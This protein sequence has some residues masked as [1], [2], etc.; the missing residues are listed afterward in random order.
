[1]GWWPTAVGMKCALAL[2]QVGEL[3]N[4]LAP[5][6]ASMRPAG[7][8]CDPLP[9]FRPAR[10]CGLRAGLPC[11][12]HACCAAPP[13][14]PPRQWRPARRQSQ[15]RCRPRP[16]AGWRCCHCFRRRL[17]HCCSQWFPGAVTA[18]RSRLAPAG[19]ATPPPCRPA[20]RER[21]RWPCNVMSGATT[22]PPGA[23]GR[24]LAPCMH[25]AAAAAAPAP[26]PEGHH[27][28]L[29]RQS[30]VEGRHVISQGGSTAQ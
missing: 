22:A 16:Q 6:A 14:R 2:R 9:P 15:R 25:G 7:W 24:T 1:M 17:C 27:D 21:G 29:G 8:R 18:Q 12:P 13:A 3:C 10:C 11:W 19:A 4:N 23:Q 5:T 28:R 20:W 30:E 26:H